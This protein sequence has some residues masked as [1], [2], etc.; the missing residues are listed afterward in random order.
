MS[1]LRL[2]GYRLA[3]AQHSLLRYVD[4]LGLSNPGVALMALARAIA[5]SPVWQSSPGTVLV[6]RPSPTPLLVAIGRFDRVRERWLET[7]AQVLSADCG[8]LRLVNYRQ[9]EKDCIRLASLLRDRLGHDE[10]RRARF[11]AIP[12]GG[13]V[14]LGLLATALGLDR[15]QLEPP[16]P[17]DLPLVAV[18]DCALSGTRIRSILR[19]YE[20]HR[21]VTL[22]HL[23]SPPE[24]RTAIE[25]EENRVLAAIAARDLDSVALQDPDTDHNARFL[26]HMKDAYSVARTEPL[27][28][29][30]GEPDRMI[31]DP[32][33]DR[34]TQAWSLVPPK[35]CF[36]NRTR[37]SIPVQVMPPVKGP[38]RPGHDVVFGELEDH[39]V[40]L[41]LSRLETVTLNG[42]ASDIWRNL[43]RHGDLATVIDE[44]LRTYAVSDHKLQREA[45]DFTDQLLDR[46][47]LEWE[48][49]ADTPDPGH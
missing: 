11:V 26:A 1:H 32:V 49:P 29:P 4:A 31:W 3:I 6:V 42:V 36:K 44:L 12:R 9:V 17:P 45:T 10:V 25:S 8:R 28:F 40:L 22:A 27:G 38:L 7:Q 47:F 34:P 18:D 16:H 23:Y 41:Q 33:E 21:Q 13:F 48:E 19:R 14:V 5:S 35:R 46:G 43:V 39:V 15:A 37:P 30:W 24:L 20:D 2:G